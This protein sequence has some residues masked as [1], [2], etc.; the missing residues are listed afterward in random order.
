MPLPL[1]LSPLQ[2]RVLPFAIFVALTFVQGW[3][4]DASRF[5]VYA[6]KTGIGAGLI[7]M[8]WPLVTEMR[9]RFNGEALAAGLLVAALWIG[10]DPFYPKL[11]SLNN[12]TPW[13]PHLAFGDQ[14]TLAWSFVVV[15]LVGSTLVVPLIEEVFYR[16]FLYR[17]LA[18][19]AFESVSLRGIRWGPF[20]ATAVV[21]GLAHHEWLAGILCAGIYQGLVC[22]R[23]RL[24][25]AITAHAFTNLLLGLWVVWKGAWHFW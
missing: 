19:P 5:W 4:G 13:N 8:V 17:Y 11:S 16:S 22:W 9:W 18:S 21:F 12:N 14:S 3:F 24:G 6:L 20:V 15:R 1:P 7:W 2:A 10:L 25:D 23:G